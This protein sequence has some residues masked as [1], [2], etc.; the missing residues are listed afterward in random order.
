MLAELELEL[1]GAVKASPV[2]AKVREIAAMPDDKPE[3]LVRKFAA[4]APAVYVVAGNSAIGDQK[5]KLRFDLVCI[6]SNSRGNDA[7]RHGD[8][9]TIGLYQ[10]RDALI[11]FLDGHKTTGAVWYAKSFDFAKAAVWR[12]N[13]LTVGSLQ[14]ETTVM[15]AGLDVSALD[16][17]I[18]FQ[19]DYDADPHQPQSEHIKWAEEPPDYTTSRPELTDTTTLPQ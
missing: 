5:E 3:V 11:A 12:D 18:T 19:A 17:F 2:F 10:M 4:Q 14:L 1:I 6:A 16:S 7:A 13:G 8:G 9:Q 15:Q